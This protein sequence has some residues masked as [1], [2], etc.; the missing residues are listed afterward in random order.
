MFCMNYF[1][2]WGRNLII[3]S[4]T[5]CPVGFPCRRAGFHQE[6]HS[7][8]FALRAMVQQHLLVQGY[9]AGPLAFNLMCCSASRVR[10]L[11]VTFLHPL[12]RRI[13]SMVYSSYR[14]YTHP[15]AHNS[16]GLV[17]TRASCECTSPSLPSADR[18][19]DQ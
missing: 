18:P 16:T 12:S 14:R 1:H 8:Q 15:S 11:P 13:L 17:V 9:S 3:T 6:F 7:C 4:I 2:P 5:F 19:S 10:A